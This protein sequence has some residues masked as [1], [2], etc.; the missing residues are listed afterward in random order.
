[1]FKK[2][3]TSTL[4][5][6][7]IFAFYCAFIIGSSWDESYEMNIGKE[8]LKYLFSF[9]TYDYLDY[10]DR[11]GWEFYPGFYHTLSTFVTKMFPKKYEIETL[12]LIN[13]SFSIFTIFPFSSS[14]SLIILLKGVCVI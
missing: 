10:R 11:L 6:L 4:V 5:I 3:E 9:G 14:I 2:V 1:M 7:I 8:R 13:W 12:H